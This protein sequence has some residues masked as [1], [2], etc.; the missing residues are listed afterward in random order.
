MEFNEHNLCEIHNYFEPDSASKILS[1][2]KALT[3]VEVNQERHGH[4]EHVFKSNDPTLPNENDFYAARFEM[5]EDREG[6]TE[7]NRIFQEKILFDIRK[8]NPNIRYYLKPNV[9]RMRKSHYF[10]SHTDAY[11]GEVGYTFFF[12]S[13]IAWSLFTFNCL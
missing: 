6:S 10:R 13:S 2:L 8:L 5:S 1:E 12:S 11:A 7:F 9:Y 4:Y 3:Y